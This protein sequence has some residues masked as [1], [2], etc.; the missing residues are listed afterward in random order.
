MMLMLCGRVATEKVRA[1]WWLQCIG[2]LSSGV[3]IVCERESEG[4]QTEHSSDAL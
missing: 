2:T 1:G 3:R 4:Q